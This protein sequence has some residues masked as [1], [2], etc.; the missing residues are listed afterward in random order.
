MSLREMSTNVFGLFTQYIVIVF[1][2][3]YYSFKVMLSAFDA[4]DE[5]LIYSLLVICFT[6]DRSFSFLSIS[7]QIIDFVEKA[8]LFF[9]D[10]RMVLVYF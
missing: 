2:Q 8:A 3:I 9:L 1:V 7:D 6:V 4:L 5:I 10:L